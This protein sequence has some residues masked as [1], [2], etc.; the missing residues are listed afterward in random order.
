MNKGIGAAIGITFI[1]VAFM[2]FPNVVD[3]TEEIKVKDVDEDHLVS[4]GAGV[5]SANIVLYDDLYDSNLTYVDEIYSS[6]GSDTPV[7]TDYNTVTRT[8]TVGGLAESTD[9]TLQI[10]YRTDALEDVV[11]IRQFGNLA[12]FLIM[13]ALIATGGGILVHVYRHR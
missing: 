7:A 10:D 4:T 13:A 6:D 11:G 3:T 2:F 8:L 9:R 1:I 5:T 12:P